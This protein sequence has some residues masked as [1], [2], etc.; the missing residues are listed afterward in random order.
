METINRCKT[1]E[2]ICEVYAGGQVRQGVVRESS[3]RRLLPGA[4]SFD[5]CTPA[6]LPSFPSAVSL[7]SVTLEN[8]MVSI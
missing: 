2:G 3:M 7:L 5:N 8:A 6:C 1:G 4:A